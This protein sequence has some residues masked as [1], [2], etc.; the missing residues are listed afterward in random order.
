MASLIAEVWIV[1]S[2]SIVDN[3]VSVFN[4]E[5]QYVQNDPKV[6]TNLVL[7]LEEMTLLRSSYL[8]NS[9]KLSSTK[10]SNIK[11]LDNLYWN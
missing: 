5:F 2:D 11:N 10:N 9:T 1:I 6:I 4:F 3:K 8:W 7:D